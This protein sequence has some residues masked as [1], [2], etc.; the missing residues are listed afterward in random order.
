MPF[1]ACIALY[2]RCYGTAEG[3]EWNV[4]DS[5]I[6]RKDEW[7]ESKNGCANGFVMGKNIC[8]M[9][10]QQL[11]FSSIIIEFMIDNFQYQMAYIHYCYSQA[12]QFIAVL[13][14]N[15]STFGQ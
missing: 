11:F 15:D 9:N 4:H 8:L 14:N 6:N 7:D 5:S 13:T 3:M 12:Y 2:Y 1:F 10:A